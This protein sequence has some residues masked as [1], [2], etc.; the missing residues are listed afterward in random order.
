M[1][2]NSFFLKKVIFYATL[3]A[4]VTINSVYVLLEGFR[5]ESVFTK[6]LMMYDANKEQQL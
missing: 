2:K 4:G 5:K 1:H 6:T 3:F